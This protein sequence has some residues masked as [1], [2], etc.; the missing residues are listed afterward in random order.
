MLRPAFRLTTDMIADVLMR[1]FLTQDEAL[2]QL[3]WPLHGLRGVLEISKHIS[4]IV[5][6]TYF[7]PLFTLF[8]LFRPLVATVFFLLTKKGNSTKC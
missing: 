6:Y 4:A 1:C 2:C 8:F 3:P 5:S 7:I